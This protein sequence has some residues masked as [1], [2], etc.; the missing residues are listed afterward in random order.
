M[1][2][3]ENMPKLWL[4]FRLYKIKNK[5]IRPSVGNFSELIFYVNFTRIIINKN[6]QTKFTEKSKIF[7][8]TY[9]KP[10]S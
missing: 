5:N 9:Y 10:S 1:N 3:S 7:K 8:K 2:D 4:A 6:W